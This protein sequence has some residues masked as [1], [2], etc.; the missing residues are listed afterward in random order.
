MQSITPVQGYLEGYYGKLFDWQDRSQMLRTL[1]SLSLNSYCYAPKEDPFHRLM[2]R[3][4]Y[5]SEWRH[6]FRNFCHEAR[7]LD[8]ATIAGIAPGLDFNFDHNRDFDHLQQKAEQLLDDGASE[9][10]ILWDDI[11][12]DFP[13]NSQSLA[14][15][16]AHARVV[17]RLAK[18]LN[19]PL[20]TVPRVYAF[21]IENKNNYIE[22]FFTELDPNHSVIFCGDAIVVSHADPAEISRRTSTNHPLILWDNFYANDYCPRRLFVGPWTG[23]DSVNS[24]LLNPT[25]M[26]KTDQLLLASAVACHKQKDKQSAWR[27][28]LAEAGVPEE[29]FNIAEFFDAPVF[30]D[31]DVVHR[32][33]IEVSSNCSESIEHCLWRWKDPL[34]REW[35]PF[36]MGLKHDLALARNSLT[37][38]RIVK[39]QSVPLA[40][41][42]LRD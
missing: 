35:Y 29:F 32:H 14:E 27:S 24:Y 36:L 17:N 26:P 12:D 15:G 33:A 18:K 3:E 6:A 42:L 13:P 1:H 25:G 39:T 20:V 7:S 19:R 31:Q 21:D 8:I 28:V 9:I 40:E 23:R 41:R 34:S 4:S 10:L 37:P 5:G 2:W 16:T 22:H 30:G 11:Q 38:D